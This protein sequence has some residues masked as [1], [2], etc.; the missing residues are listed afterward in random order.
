MMSND[1]QDG[2]MSKMTMSTSMILNMTLKVSSER[3]VLI[4]DLGGATALSQIS[5]HHIQPTTFFGGDGVRDQGAKV[6]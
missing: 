5:P 2:G 1:N 4:F 6:T 3:K